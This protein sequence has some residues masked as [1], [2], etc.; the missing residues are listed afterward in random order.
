MLLPNDVLTRFSAKRSR[1][2]TGI[3]FALLLQT[4]ALMYFLFVINPSS[5]TSGNDSALATIK[6]RMEVS[7]HRHSIFH[8]TGENDSQKLGA[9]ITSLN[10]D[11]VV[12]CGGDG[13]VQLAAK[14][15]IGTNKMLGIIPLGSANGLATALDIPNDVDNA[16]TAIIEKANHVTLDL[17]KINGH[18]CIHLSDI[19]TNALLIKNY[20]EAGDKGMIGYAKHLL[21]SIRESERMSYTIKTDQETIDTQGYMLMIANANQYGTGVKIS[22]GSVSDGK[23]ELCNVAELTLPAAV[24]AGLTA[25]NVFV[26]R[27][28]FANVISCTHAEIQVSRMVHL[29]IDGEYMGEVDKLVV[30]I[31]PGAFRVIV[32]A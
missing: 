30:E 1:W 7:G 32:P 24:K 15:L 11:C 6:K 17:L 14:L 19:G 31:I 26:D 12:A 29:Q 25:L 28:M 5:G 21:S 4:L 10:P 16:L 23:F 18:I 22:D 3:D 8:T 20:E 9:E 27:N 13:T 2:Q